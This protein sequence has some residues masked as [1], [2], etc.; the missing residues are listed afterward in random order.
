MYHIYNKMYK[1]NSIGQYLVNGEVKIDNS[2]N[3]VESKK[4]TG[5]ETKK[6]EQPK[7]TET[8]TNSLELNL[9]K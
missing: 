6:L 7:P 3:V 5:S 1:Y 8:F 9:T 2:T 4:E